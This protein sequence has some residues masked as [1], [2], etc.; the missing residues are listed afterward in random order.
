M[1]TIALLLLL[2][3]TTAQPPSTTTTAGAVDDYQ[4]GV[5]D[6]I[7]VTVFGEPD[8]SRPEAIVDSDGTIDMPYIGRVKVAGQTARGAEKEM[9][10][11]FKTILVNPAISVD[12]VR[13]RSKIISV[14]G[15]VGSPG[16]YPL[17]GNVSVT[18]AIAK[19]GSL[20]INAGSFVLINRRAE[21]GKPEQQIKVSRKDIESGRA[22]S[23]FL[24]DGDTVMVPKAETVLVYGQVRSPGSVT[25]EED[26]TVERAMT[27]AGGGTDRAGRVDIERNGKRVKKGAKKTDIVQ[28]NDTIRVQTRIL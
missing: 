11:R 6:V 7:R 24:K 15:F 21:P 1:K 8:A 23:V 17:E 18:S 5:A 19:A 28:A 13:Y 10:E 14:V 9:R 12:I 3:Q 4:I 22:Q 26:L 20:L 2:A 27:L 25:W 16:E